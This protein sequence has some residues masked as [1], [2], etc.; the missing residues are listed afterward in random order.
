M[1]FVDDNVISR[2]KWNRKV[3]KWFFVVSGDKLCRQI[4]E[5][6]N[7]EMQESGL[8]IF[9]NSKLNI[10]LTIYYC[11]PKI[12]YKFNLKPSQVIFVD[13]LSDSIRLLL[14]ESIAGTS[15]LAE[16]FLKSFDSAKPPKGTRTKFTK[17]AVG[18]IL[19]SLS[20]VHPL[21]HKCVA[22]LMAFAWT[23]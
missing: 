8:T 20:S 1:H 3:K 22:I 10:N 14:E 21:I 23:C 7:K 6:L 12:F 5:R 9:A 19:G 18:F 4:E 16:E 13:K 17:V 15:L 11:L 2:N